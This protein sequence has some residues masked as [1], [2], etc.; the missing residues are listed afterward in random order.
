M[1]ALVLQAVK[2][3]EKEVLRSLEENCDLLLIVNK[4]VFVF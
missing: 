1:A 2:K 4:K 3:Q